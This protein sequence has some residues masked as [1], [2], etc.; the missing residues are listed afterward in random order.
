M[1]DIISVDGLVLVYVDETRA[2]DNVSLHLQEWES[3]LA[4]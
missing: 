4:P 1:S 2:V 3:S